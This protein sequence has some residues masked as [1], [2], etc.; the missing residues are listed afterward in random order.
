M[1]GLTPAHLLII[2]IIA[3]VVI[4]PGKLPEVGAAIGR[5]IR[6]FQKASGGLTDTLTRAA[7]GALA[8]AQPA[9]VPYPLASADAAQTALDGPRND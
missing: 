9:P 7:N 8:Q 5:S 6:E 2:L 3:L 1:A 4:G